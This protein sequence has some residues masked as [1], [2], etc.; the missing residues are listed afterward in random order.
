MQPTIDTSCLWT[1]GAI[2]KVTGLTP[3]AINDR[4]RRG[5]FIGAV[6]QDEHGTRFFEPKAVIDFFMGEATEEMIR[7]LD[8]IIQS[9]T[10]KSADL[11]N[12]LEV[13]RGLKDGTTDIL[14]VVKDLG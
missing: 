1:T 6:A 12:A 8:I 10:T 5:R 2:A 11:V 4:I 7:V 13:Q 9:P 14:D 3:Q